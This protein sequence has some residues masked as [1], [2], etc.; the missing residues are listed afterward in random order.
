MGK[1]EQSCFSHP[2][3]IV[4]QAGP[5]PSGE[6]ATEGGGGAKQCG[7]FFGKWCVCLVLVAALL[8]GG[9]IPGRWMQPLSYQ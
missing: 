1:K 3:H 9:V 7:S 2:Y 4:S 5:Q 6:E 8:V